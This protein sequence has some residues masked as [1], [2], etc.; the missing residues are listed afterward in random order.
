MDGWIEI[1]IKKMDVCMDKWI[2]CQT[3]EW[4]DRRIDKKR[5][6]DGQIEIY[7]QIK[8]MSG[9]MGRRMDR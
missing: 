9:W 8:R 5:W 3:N 4:I 2:D 7:M 1:Q 6:M